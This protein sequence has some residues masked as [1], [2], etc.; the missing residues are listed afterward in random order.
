MYDD[1]DSEERSGGERGPKRAGDVLIPVPWGNG[2]V[3][4]PAKYLSSALIFV[5]MGGGILYML[6]EHDLGQRTALAE[7]IVSRDH[8]LDSVIKKQ[9]DLN[10]NM[11]IMIY[12]LSRPE[13]ERKRMNLTMPAAMR[14]KLL[15]NERP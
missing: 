4:F 5:M 7:A 1:R 12:V 9:D 8:K 10:D 14:R 15:D 11:E 3:R 6:R 13:D 2:S